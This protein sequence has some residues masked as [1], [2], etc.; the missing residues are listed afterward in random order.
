MLSAQRPYTLVRSL[1]ISEPVPR[2]RFHPNNQR[3]VKPGFT[4]GWS[5]SG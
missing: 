1:W 5:N 4:P 2:T 3:I